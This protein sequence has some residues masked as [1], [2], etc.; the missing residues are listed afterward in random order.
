MN[1]SKISR[2]DFHTLFGTAM[3]T[4]VLGGIPVIAQAAGTTN[5][6]SAMVPKKGGRVRL[7]LAQQ[8]TNDTFD[9]A[10]FTNANDYIR[11]SAVFNTLTRVDGSGQAQPELALSWEANPSA[12]E[13]RF[14]IRKGV[15]FSDG[16]PLSLQDIAFSIMRH[17]NE[18]K[19]SSAKPLVA[20]IAAVT[21]EGD[22][23]ILVRLAEADVELPVLLGLLQ[24]CVVKDGTEDFSKPIGT[25]PFVMSEFQPGIRTVL[26][27]NT[28]FWKDGQPYLDEIEMIS[29]TD[30]NARVSAL[31]SGDIDMA[32]DLK[33]AGID[34]VAAN[35]ST[36]I[37]ETPSTRYAGYQFDAAT[38]FDPNLGLAIANMFDRPK[39]VETV[40]KG[41]GS[42]AND[43]PVGKMSP[44]YN[45][46][47]PQRELDLDKAK[48]YLK[49]SG[50]GRT[51]LELS[52]SDGVV[53]SVEIAQLLQR[54]A[55]QAGLN[56]TLRREPSE[57]YWTAVAGKRRFFATN[58]FPRPTPH[59]LLNVTWKSGSQWNFSHYGNPRLDSLIDGVRATLDVDKRIAMYHEIQEILHN[60][61]AVTMPVFLSYLDGVSSRI[62]GLTP[63]Q[64]GNF[65]G[66]RFSDQ[67]WLS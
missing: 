56:L 1:F 17:K 67:V 3:G 66:F 9:S 38:N 43:H 65:S 45:A 22:D 13:W 2:R 46:N 30:A 32:A 42:V 40:L 23:T 27:R 19:A 11:G 12:T 31:L 20:N 10:R 7:A 62:Q 52:V 57:S 49:K 6:P 60:C 50:I 35:P 64:I 39:I 8:S 28:N 21:T 16:Q 51:P 41:H 58:F 33:G 5:S 55:A 15:E 61:G 29:I 24:F 48:H 14:K 36:K 63:N 18:G 34:Q 54:S 25:G 26:T 53:Y 44:Y 37:F 4:A 47:L 59:L